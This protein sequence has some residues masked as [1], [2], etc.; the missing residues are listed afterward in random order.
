MLFGEGINENVPQST[1]EDKNLKF[2]H[3]IV[4]SN[5]NPSQVYTI[6]AVSRDSQRNE[7]QSADN[8][9]VTPSRTDSA[10]ELILQNVSDIFGI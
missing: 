3:V 8:V 5:L 9:T 4:I 10:L 6:R 1:T 2:N 7:T